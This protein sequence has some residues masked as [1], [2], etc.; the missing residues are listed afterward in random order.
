MFPCFFYFLIVFSLS[1]SVQ[2]KS[3]SAKALLTKVMTVANLAGCVVTKSP[4]NGRVDA[5]DLTLVSIPAE[6]ILSFVG[7]NKTLS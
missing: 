3:A 2:A 7:K 4:I 5:K 1:F 6:Q